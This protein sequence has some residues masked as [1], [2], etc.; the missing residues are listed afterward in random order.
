MHRGVTRQ[1]LLSNHTRHLVR[2]LE[3]LL[4][5]DCSWATGRHCFILRSSLGHLTREKTPSEED[6]N[7]MRAFFINRGNNGGADKRLRGKGNAC[8]SG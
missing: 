6:T 3:K 8:S 2:K 4:P 1:I 5:N 7:G